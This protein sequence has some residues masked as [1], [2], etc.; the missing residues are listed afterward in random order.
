MA[1]AFSVLSSTASAPS[2]AN[3]QTYANGAPSN[4]TATSSEFTLTAL[5]RWSVANKTLPPVDKIR[6]LHVYDFDNTRTNIPQ[7]L[8]TPNS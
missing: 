8:R 3:Y 2:S 5:G 1:S 4:A 6:A 7:S